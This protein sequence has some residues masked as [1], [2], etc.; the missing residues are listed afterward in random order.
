MSYII[1]TVT[2]AHE[3]AD[4]TIKSVLE[5]RDY[6]KRITVKQRMDLRIWWLKWCPPIR[7]F[8]NELNEKEAEKAEYGLYNTNWWE[9]HGC[10]TLKVA[11]EIKHLATHSHDG[12]V[13]ISSDHMKHLGK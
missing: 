6:V 5:D 3:L 2:K 7:L 12:F 1:I 8:F 13:R 11:N 9:L 4:R 10:E